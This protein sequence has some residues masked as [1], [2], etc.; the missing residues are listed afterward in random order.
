MSHW[1]NP[2][3]TDLS[4]VSG[5]DRRC[6]PTHRHELP[7]PNPEKKN[8]KKKIK[9]RY[10]PSVLIAEHRVSVTHISL[11]VYTNT[12]AVTFLWF[13]PGTCSCKHRGSEITIWT[14]QVKAQRSRHSQHK[15]QSSWRM[16]HFHQQHSLS[17]RPGRCILAWKKT[18][19][20]LSQSRLG[21][22]KRS[23]CDDRHG[24]PQSRSSD[25]IESPRCAKGKVA[26]HVP[27]DGSYRSWILWCGLVI[28]ARAWP[29]RTLKQQHENYE[30]G[31]SYNKY[32]VWVFI[33]THPHGHKMYFL[34]PRQV[35]DEAPRESNESVWILFRLSP[36]SAFTNIIKYLK[37]L[38]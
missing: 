24:L 31:F 21:R 9:R 25:A 37:N 22:K 6:C 5:P 20:P 11:H 4:L 7:L 19:M 33:F 32:S 23:V 27:E 36:F 14:A 35:A 30:K 10:D 15:L 18:C 29:L 17:A 12:N 3:N 8:Q 38:E 13:A 1:A 34:Y 2:A 26:Y 16:Q 28:V